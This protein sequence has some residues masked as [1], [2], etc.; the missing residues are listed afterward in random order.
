MEVFLA[1]LKQKF[2]ASVSTVLSPMVK[3]PPM[4]TS[5]PRQ[6]NVDFGK[7]GSEGV[8]GAGEATSTKSPYT[9]NGEADSFDTVHWSI[10]TL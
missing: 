7:E 4:Y 6:P 2:I 5:L 10:I 3:S 9:S 1:V 8:E